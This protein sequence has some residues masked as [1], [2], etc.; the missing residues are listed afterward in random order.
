MDS[1]IRASIAVVALVLLAVSLGACGDTPVEVPGVRGDA[2]GDDA[3]LEASIDAEAPVD[4]EA[5][6]LPGDAQAPLPGACVSCYPGTDGLTNEALKARLSAL[7]HP[8]TALGYGNTSDPMMLDLDNREGA[9]AGRLLGH[10][11]ATAP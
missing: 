6:T 10:A 7:I 5:P 11:M 4:S 3:A 1:P 2:S 9:Q 8:H